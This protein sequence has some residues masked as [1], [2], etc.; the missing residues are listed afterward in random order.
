[1]KRLADPAA[2]QEAARIIRRGGLV[3]FPTETVYGLGADAANPE[4]VA[5]VF[6][7]KGRP[8]FD[9]LIVH[10]A[11]LDQ[12]RRLWRSCP[13]MAEQLMQ[14][15]WPGPL[16]I[17]LP[18]VDTVPD[19]VTSG[20]DTVAVRMPDHPVARQL[21]EQAQTPIAAPSANR[22]GRPSPT[23]ADAVEEEL[24]GRV[25]LIL[26]AGPTRVGIESTVV[27]IEG[28]RLVLLRPG[29]VTLE[30]LTQLVGPVA[31]G[32][33]RVADARAAASPGL[34]ERHYAPTTPLYLL[35][36]GHGSIPGT[37]TFASKV[38]VPGCQRVAASR[39]G[40]LTLGPADATVQG[41]GAHEILSARADVVEAA[42][43]FFQA[44][45][46][47]DAQGL[48]A[49]IAQPLPESGL[50]RA[51]MDRLRRASVGAA[52]W[53]GSELVLSRRQGWARSSA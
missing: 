11:S 10:V 41:A 20:L 25:E 43:R 6:D 22:F 35:E 4:A 21:I 40:L 34:L 45:R 46:R 50:G 33:S 8:R 17:A 42:A 44:I 2:I 30:T 19:L 49:I 3:A 48:E 15:L 14:A 7:A 38:C 37:H 39:V 12:A 1:M 9:P 23:T 24:G 52:W 13:P 5:R 29:G 28:E 31:L 32:P 47:L 16:T 26:D 53:D 18:K 27:A 36:L 51:L